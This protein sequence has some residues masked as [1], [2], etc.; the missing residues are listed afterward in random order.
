[1]KTLRITVNGVMAT[2]KSTVVGIRLDHE[3][4]AWVEGE[5]ARLGV[6]VRGLFEGMID[7]ARSTEEQAER[8]NAGLGSAAAGTGAA[9]AADAST[10]AADP[11]VAT[12]SASGDRV[13]A[14]SGSSATDAAS[15]SPWPGV[16]SVTAM[17]AGLIR[18][19]FSLTASLIELS[20][21]CATKRLSSCA[22]TRRWSGRSL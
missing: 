16:G 9:P 14:S 3:R 5:A 13:N 12:S 21:R 6:S 18:E 10:A 22:L 19:A 20:G 1:M 2:S 8:A 4:R 7:E 11:E 15:S 17:P